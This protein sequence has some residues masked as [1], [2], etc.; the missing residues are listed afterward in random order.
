MASD[1]IAAIVKNGRET[2]ISESHSTALHRR[3]MV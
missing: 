1:F 2:S 3:G